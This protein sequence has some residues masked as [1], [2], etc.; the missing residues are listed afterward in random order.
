MF[1]ERINKEIEGVNSAQIQ[2]KAVEDKE[3][4]I[5]YEF[6]KVV[7]PESIYGNNKSSFL[8]LDKETNIEFIECTFLGATDFSLISNSKDIYFTSSC[9]FF[10]YT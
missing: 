6:I 7:F 4:K 10:E 5:N 9:G 8:S 3:Y 2:S 1:W